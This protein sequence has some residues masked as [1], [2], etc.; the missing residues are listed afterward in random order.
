MKGMTSRS[1]RNDKSAGISGFGSKEITLDGFGEM[2][3]A[4]GVA[5]AGGGDRGLVGNTDPKRK[6]IV[7]GFEP[8]QTQKASSAGDVQV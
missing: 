7:P 2:Y 4:G 1:E 8:L 5:G 3:G 6:E